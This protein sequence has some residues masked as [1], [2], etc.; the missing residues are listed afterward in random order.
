MEILIFISFNVPD[1]TT[2]IHQEVCFA[3]VGERLMCIPAPKP[4]LFSTSA[5]WHVFLQCRQIITCLCSFWYS[6]V[7][8]NHKVYCSSMLDVVTFISLQCRCCNYKEKITSLFQVLPWKKCTSWT[9]S[10]CISIR[11]MRRTTRRGYNAPVTFSLSSLVH[12]FWQL[13][14]I[15]ALCLALLCIWSEV[16]F[17]CSQAV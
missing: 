5:P 4:L 10:Y 1:I 12:F 11:L 2:Q 16:L 17:P 3:L 6:D 15:S 9:R 8:I 7:N 13:R 14:S